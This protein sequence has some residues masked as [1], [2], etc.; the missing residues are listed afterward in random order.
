MYA[1]LCETVFVFSTGAMDFNYLCTM[2]SILNRCY[3]ATANA[4]IAGLCVGEVLRSC[5]NLS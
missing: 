3:K 2:G 4:R 1:S 5:G